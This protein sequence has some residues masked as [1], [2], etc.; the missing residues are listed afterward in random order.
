MDARRQ[1]ID[2]A[3][4]LLWERGF[5]AMSPRAVLERSGA[6]QGSLYHHFRGKLDL[7][8]AALSETSEELC[9]WLDERFAEGN[10]PLGTVRGWLGHP[11]DALKGCRM[12]RMAAEAAIRDEAIRHPVG[13]YFTRLEQKLA[14]AIGEA[15]EAGELPPGLDPLDLAATLSATVQGGYVLARVRGDDGQM[16]RAVRGALSLLEHVARKS[17]APVRSRRNGARRLP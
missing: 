10:S 8:A 14:S 16:K 7:A 11:R 15:I 2:A 4:D 5:E 6:G 13:L 3:K 12:G 9:G 17:A 1:L